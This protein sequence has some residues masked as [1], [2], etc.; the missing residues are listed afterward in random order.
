[1]EGRGYS[2][3][4]GGSWVLYYGGRVVGTPLWLEGREYFMMEGGSWDFIM[5]GRS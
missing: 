3:I 2:I 4:G 1:M 5:E